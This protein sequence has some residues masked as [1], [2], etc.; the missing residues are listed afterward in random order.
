M[1]VPVMR[2]R[3]VGMPMH[4]R[5]VVMPVAMLSAGRQRFDVRVLVVLV[6][7]VFV[8]VREPL[9]EVLMFVLLGQVQ[10]HA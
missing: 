4:H 10:P 2:V 7:H 5:F 1:S 9:M 8:L 3:K 6:V